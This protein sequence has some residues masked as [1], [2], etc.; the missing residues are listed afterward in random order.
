M[1]GTFHNALEGGG[2]RTR[3]E[4][5]RREQSKGQERRGQENTGQDRTGQE[6]V[7]DM[8][9]TDVLFSSKR[10]IKLYRLLSEI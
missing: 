6:G 4:V 1:N 2:E 8:E 5:T 3:R 7:R 9:M 10:S